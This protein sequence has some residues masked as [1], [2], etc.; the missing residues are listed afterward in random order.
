MCFT[1]W[2][3]P[4]G[5]INSVKKGCSISSTMNGRLSGF[6]SRHLHSCAFA[7]VVANRNR[8]KNMLKTMYISIKLVML[9]GVLCVCA[10]ACLHYMVLINE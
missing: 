5:P 2:S 7:K 3:L 6:F 1:W 4:V 8:K 10:S 9:C